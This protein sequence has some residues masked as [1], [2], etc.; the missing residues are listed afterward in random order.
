[1]VYSAI[2]F[3]R[4]GLFHDVGTQIKKVLDSPIRHIDELAVQ[5][6]KHGDIKAFDELFN[7][8]SQRLYNFSLKYLKEDEGAEDVVQEV[9]LYIREK[10]A[11]LKPEELFNGT[12][13][14]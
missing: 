2:G 1:M 11:G 7:K 10:R 3:V 6:L 5:K 13:V 4:V 14:M 12:S 8:Y 9:F